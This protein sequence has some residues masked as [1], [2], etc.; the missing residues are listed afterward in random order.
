MPARIR[1]GLASVFVEDQEAAVRFYTEKLDFVIRTDEKV[2]EFRFVTVSSLAGAEGVEL[3]LEPNVHPAASAFQKAI[4]ADG[5]P[6]T[7]FFVFDV[8]AA[9]KRLEERGVVFTMPPTDTEFGT[10]AIFDDTC[11]NLIQLFQK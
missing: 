7:T 11:G 6:A 8:K 9:V 4:K 1:I 10:M 2:G 5:I 3:L